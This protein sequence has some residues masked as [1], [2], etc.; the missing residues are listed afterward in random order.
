MGA[1]EHDV[2]LGVDV[3]AIQALK[4][5]DNALLDN[6]A[7][8]LSIGVD[9]D[10]ALVLVVWLGYDEGTGV[11]TLQ[12]TFAGLSNLGIAHEHD[13]VDGASDIRNACTD[14]VVGTR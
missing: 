2:L 3:V 10:K 7:H 11:D 5:L 14:K 9:K 12:E 13:I 8:G 1:G 4:T 6:V